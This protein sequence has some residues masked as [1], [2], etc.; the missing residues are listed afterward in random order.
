MINIQSIKELFYRY[1]SKDQ[2]E[3]V[4]FDYMANMILEDEPENES[5][6]NALIGDYLT[7][8][9]KY[10]EERI[11]EICKDLLEEMVK[12]GLKSARKAIIAERLTKAVK[13]SDVKVGSENTI[14]SLNFDPNLFVFEKQ[15]DLI[16]LQGMSNIVK[17][18][19]SE[20]LIKH[21]ENVAKSKENLPELQMHHSRDESHKVDIIVPSFTI[22]IA[23]KTLM[24]DS[25]LKINFGSR[26]V[27]IGRNGIGKTTLLN[28]I[29]RKEID[30]I[31]KHLQILHV[32]QEVVAN[33]NI[34][35]DEVLNCDVERR[36]LLSEN[37]EIG[38]FFKNEENLKNKELTDK[39]SKRLVEVAKRL[40][41]IDADLAEAKAIE[42]LRGLGFNQPDFKKPTKQFSGGWRMRIS[43]AK[44]LFVQPDILL[45]DEPT[46]HLDMNAVM[47]LEDYLNSWPYTLIVVSHARDFINA[48]ATDIIYFTNLKL[49]PWS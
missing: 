31:P 24:E 44:A 46:N 4:V 40:Q 29:A 9:L 33:D 23:G 25:P 22:S 48:I 41:Y 8:Q 47:W 30:G 34:L 13:L 10:D 35:L 43:L 16:E 19:K 32:E 5:D 17:K 26:Y 42:I 39:Y 18:D 14:T 3:D 6:L 45:L 37:L 1:L 38:E 27:L 15:K 20:A 28:H 12:L 7:D 21:L 2:F 36:N 49:Y 11:H